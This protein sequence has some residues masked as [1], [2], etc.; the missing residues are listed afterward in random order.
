[1]Q[2]RF[3]LVILVPHGTV[4]IAGHTKQAS[5]FQGHK[6]EEPP[7]LCL[8]SPLQ[9]SCESHQRPRR[10][11]RTQ[12]LR[13]AFRAV[14]WRREPSVRALQRAAPALPGAFGPIGW[15]LRFQDRHGGK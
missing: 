4:Q 10:R 8:R 2:D 14:I 5:G 3:C 7:G 1:M 9:S 12:L 6:L 11:G 15:A 13:G